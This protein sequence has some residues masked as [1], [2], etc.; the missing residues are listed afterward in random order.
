[1]TIDSLVESYQKGAITADHLVANCLHQI[2]P[3]NPGLVLDAL[4][5]EILTRMLEFAQRY[6]PGGMVT[7][8]GSLPAVDQVEAAK[9]WIESS[10]HP[11]GNGDTPNQADGHPHQREAPIRETSGT[12]PD[13]SQ[14]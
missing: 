1:V 9:R 2:D 4:P 10:R 3:A 8:Y 5:G 11:L 6:R 14:P 13:A 12:V 7:N